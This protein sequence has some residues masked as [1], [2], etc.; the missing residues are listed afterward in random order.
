MTMLIGKVVM[1]TGG[2]SG[3]GKATCI[4][5]AREGAKVAVCD[6]LAA[7]GEAVAQEIRN[8]GGDAIYVQFDVLKDKD[9]KEGIQKV[10]DYYGTLH[11]AVNSAG[12]LG[13]KAALVAST[14]QNWD[15]VLEINLKS[16]WRCMKHQLRYMRDNGGGSIVNMSSDAGLAGVSRLPAYTASKHGVIGL[17]KSAALDYAKAN[18]RVNAV[19]PGYTDTPLFYADSSNLEDLMKWIKDTMPMGRLAKP[20]EVAE[21]AIWL[22]SDRSSYITGHALVVDGGILAQ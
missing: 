11:G 22:C 13:M 12:I 8:A 19:C 4:A 5:L 6:I 16:I 3:I 7:E 14:E 21:A 20:E 9:I 15:R 18:I 17:T 2:S 1:V 10:V